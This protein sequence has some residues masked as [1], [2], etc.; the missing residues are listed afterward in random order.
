MHTGLTKLRS[1]KMDSCKALHPKGSDHFR[2]LAGMPGLT[3]LSWAAHAGKPDWIEPDASV[4]G[5]E[6]GAMCLLMHAHKLTNLQRSAQAF[7]PAVALPLGSHQHTFLFKAANPGN[8]V[9]AFSLPVSHLTLLFSS[10]ILVQRY[11]TYGRLQVLR[12]STQSF[13][14]LQQWLEVL[15]VCAADS[16][17]LRTASARW[18]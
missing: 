13:H 6:I 4:A 8:S 9:P 16:T 10:T 18:T 1:L 3:E 17:C 11:T 5:A 15:H 2:F 12:T 14:E 7:S